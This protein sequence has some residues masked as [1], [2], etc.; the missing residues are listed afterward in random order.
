LINTIGG[1]MEVIIEEEPYDQ[2]AEKRASMENN[3]FKFST[4]QTL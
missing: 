4:T 1:N 3:P 2:S